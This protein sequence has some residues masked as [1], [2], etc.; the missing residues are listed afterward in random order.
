MSR[1]AARFAAGIAIASFA[2][3]GGCSTF[4]VRPP[5]KVAPGVSEAGSCTTSRVLPT[6]DTII[7]AAQGANTVFLVASDRAGDQREA[8]IGLSAS[9]V[10]SFTASAIYGFVVTGKCRDLRAGGVNP[11]Q[12]PAIRKTRAERRSEEAAEEA[13]VQARMREQAAAEAKA[14]GEAAQHAVPAGRPAAAPA[15]TP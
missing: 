2:L 14:A 4:F 1:V 12:P 8:A 7:A 6:V 3:T 9:L 5:T 15:T 11:Y 10:A 13:A